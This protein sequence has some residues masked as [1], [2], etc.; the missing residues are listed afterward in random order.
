MPG[1]SGLETLSRIKNIRPEIPVVMIT[2]SEEEDIMDEA[3]G[4][5]IADY[6]I[7]PV[8]PKQILLSIKKNLD[9]ERLVSEK[10]TSHYQSEFSHIGIQISESLSF[11]DWVTVY[12]KLVYW[13]LELETSAGGEMEEVF[14]YQKAEANKEFAK[15]I[16]KNYLSWFDANNTN[17]KPLISPNLLR[18]KVFPLLDQGHKVFFILIDN[19]RL[20]QWR[21]LYSDLK[22]YYAIENE[23]LYCSI[24]PSTTQY[25]RNALFSGLMPLEM[26]KMNPQ[27]WI[28]DDDEGSKNLNEDEFLSKQ[29]SRFGKTYKMYYEKI[30]NRKTEKKILKNINDLMHN[31][32]TVLVYNFVDM[33]SHARTNMDMIKELADDE[34]A[35]R[36]LTLSW[37][38]HSHL[39]E[40]L[41]K[42]ANEKVKVVITTDHGSIKVENPIK[43]IGDRE[44]TTN[45]RFKSGKSLNYNPKEVFEIRDV[46]KAHLP[47]RPISHTY[48]FAANNDYFVYPN[49]YN[50]FV[51]YYRS[52]FQH[53]GISLDEMMIP[54][55]VLNPH[56]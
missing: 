24:L 48:I 37:F 9:Q 28:N 2:K 33:L 44:T 34:S 14:H 42:L 11:S 39:R 12:K 22:N 38:K 36:T 35:Y 19:L 47:E 31:Q 18:T 4:S 3:I 50:H 6:L 21:V 43:V 30:L 40:M 52:T 7:K 27:L 45:L 41:I 55:V 26:S 1:I 8:N 17:E 49:N 32:L 20:D 15:Y 13:E 23:Y 51:N 10:T 46:R 29:I 25:A 53:G 5:K 56:S 16:K 54:I